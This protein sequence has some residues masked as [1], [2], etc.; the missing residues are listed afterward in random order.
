MADGTD[1]GKL[2]CGDTHLLQ[3]FLF[4]AGIP[5]L[6]ATNEERLAHY[7]ANM[8]QALSSGSLFYASFNID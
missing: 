7:H 6:P 3:R 8:Q 5:Y 1:F 2:Y 4:Y